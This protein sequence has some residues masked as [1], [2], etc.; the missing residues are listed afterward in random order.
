MFESFEHLISPFHRQRRK[1]LAVMAGSVQIGGHAPIVMQSMTTTPTRDIKATVDQCIRLAESGCEMIRITAPGVNDA[2]AL[3]EIRYSFSEHGFSKVPLVADIHFLPKAAME[4]VEHVEK[5][6]VNPGNYADKKSQ[7]KESYTDEEYQSE[8]QRVHE[9]FSPLVLRAKELGRCLRIGV[10]HGSLSDRVMNRYGDTPEGMV[11]SAMEFIKIAE[12]HQFDQMVVSM[13]SSNPRVMVEAYRKLVH[14][15]DEHGVHYPLHLGVTEAGDGDDGRIKGASGIG[16]LL[17]DGIGDTVRVSLTEEPE[18]EIPVCKDLI[19]QFPEQVVSNSLNPVKKVSDK[20]IRIFKVKRDGQTEVSIGEKMPVVIGKDKSDTQAD[21]V[22]NEVK[23][24]FGLMRVHSW[25][26]DHY[27]DIHQSCVFIDLRKQPENEIISILAELPSDNLIS[28]TNS[29]DYEWIQA[30]RYLYQLDLK[31]SFEYK[32]SLCI[33]L[34]GESSL[35]KVSSIAGALLIDHI[36][37]ALYMPNLEKSTERCLGILQAVKLRISKADYVSC[38]SCGRTLF[39]LQEV[40]EQVREVTHHLKG[41][42]IAVMGCIV[43]GPGEMADADFGYVGTGPGLVTL[44]KG[45]EP[46]VKNIPGEDARD[47]LVELIKSEGKWVDP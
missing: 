41:V 45:Y 25:E 7:A 36:G 11:I 5:V 4:A 14:A 33:A 23:D 39:D 40:T 24:E 6:R 34:E 17:A 29:G 38:P 42:T 46:V 10:N 1:S 47:Q 21:F 22:L 32:H 13:K 27:G 19:S 8:L 20:P 9:R 3:K 30:Y 28:L 15:L 31:S 18:Y 35:V 16:T 2:K 26:L 44:Y 37:Q 43:N 12:S